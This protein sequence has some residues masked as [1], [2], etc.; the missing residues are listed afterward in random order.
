MFK[1]IEQEK[2]SLGKNPNK[3]ER[4]NLPNKEFRSMVIRKLNKHGERNDEKIGRTQ[5]IQSIISK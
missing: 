3:T 1:T 2:K 4:N 5:I